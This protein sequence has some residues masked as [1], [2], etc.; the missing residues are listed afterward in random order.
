MFFFYLMNFFSTRPNIVQVN[1]LAG[2]VSTWLENYNE[3]WYEKVILPRDVRI[4]S[5]T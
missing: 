3:I 1:V 2:S 5:K 4:F